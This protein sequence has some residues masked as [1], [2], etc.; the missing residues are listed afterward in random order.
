MASADGTATIPALT[1]P[2]EISVTH[3]LGGAPT[4]IQISPQDNLGGRDF[5]VD[6]ARVTST[7][8]YIEISSLDI[9]EDHSFY[10]YAEN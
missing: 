10:W 6:P 5:W 4:G 9:S 1:D 8:F 7:V 3:T 2:A